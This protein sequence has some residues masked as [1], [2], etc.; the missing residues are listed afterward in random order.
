MLLLFKEKKKEEPIRV[1]K[2]LDKEVRL[3]EGPWSGCKDVICRKD[4][5]GFTL[6]EQWKEGREGGR[7]EA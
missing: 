4:N 2:G 3:R 7:W 5:V 6:H 1:V